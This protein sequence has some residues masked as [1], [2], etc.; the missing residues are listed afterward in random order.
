MFR[1]IVLGVLLVTTFFVTRGQ[2]KKEKQVADAVEK[3]RVAMVD[4]NKANLESMVSDKLSYGH[5]GGHLEG[6]A[7]F[8]E[9]IVSGKSDFVTIELKDQTISI[10]GKT[11]IVR[12]I[13]DAKTNDS[14]K[15]GEVHLLVLM[16]WQ[17]EGGRWILIARQAVHPG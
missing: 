3:L 12:H 15:P 13:L 11:A 5:S 10:T 9:K 14:G 8:V 2:S 17:K 6:K 1:K 4:A 7:E 16:V